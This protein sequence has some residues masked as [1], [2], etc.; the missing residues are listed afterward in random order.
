MP[1][2]RKLD[3]FILGSAQDVAQTL[4]ET[5]WESDGVELRALWTPPQPQQPSTRELE[6]RICEHAKVSSENFEQARNLQ[7]KT[8]RKPIGQI[9]LD[10]GAVTESDLLTCLAK[11][12][13]LPF[14]RLEKSDIDPNAAAMLDPG[15]IAV[16]HVLP[17]RFENNRL[18]VATADPTNVFM[19]DEVKRQTGKEIAVCVTTTED[20]NRITS[21]DT[22]DDEYH[23]DDIIQDIAEDD[24]EVV[25]AEEEDLSNLAREAAESPIIKFVNYII[26]NAVKEGASDIHIEPGE[27]KLKVRYRIDGVL[28]EMMN[29]PSNM[30][31][32]VVSRI[33]IMASLDISERRLPQDGRI[34]VVVNR[35]DVDMRVSTL[36]TS[37][38]EKVVIRIMDATTTQLSLADLGF[39]EDTLV[40]LSHQVAQPHG[41]V[42]VT[43]PTGSGKSTTLYACLQTMNLNKLN[44]STVE[45]PVEFQVDG[46]TQVQVHDH[47]GMSFSAALRSLLRQDPDVI[48]VGE[49]RDGETAKIAVQA[50]LTGHLVLSTLHTNDAPS[51]ITRLI[52]IG[53]E[54]YL[55]AAS[56]NA[57]LAQRLVRRI[58]PHCKEAYPISPD[59]KQFMEMHGFQDDQLHKGIGCE[60]CRHTGFQGRI[61]LYELLVIDDSYRDIITKNPNVTELRRLCVERG[62]ITL[63]QDGFRKV[64]SGT[65]TVEEVMRVTESTI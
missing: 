32:A 15:F 30:H 10:M 13:E 60:N 56:T 1:N 18:V 59:N 34:R 5:G 4:E 8:P 24:V 7:S 44:V 54:P 12:L 63:R 6:H 52:N 11:Q 3:E 39:E 64:H 19:L 38:G 20:I 16:H 2:S 29:P 55:I 40:I 27:K 9:L 28:F 33:K 35:R 31:A 48:M 42:L 25:D 45:D 58:C 46:V 41:I 61:G 49:I 50:S 65:T 53:V 57:V 22:K 14:T 62:M 37:H 23:I 26:F 47:I 17:V 21:A 43:G 36:P 51:S